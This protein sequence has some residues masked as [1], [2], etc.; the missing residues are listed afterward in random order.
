MPSYDLEQ[1]LHDEGF[2]VVCGVD[3]AGRGPLCGSVVAAA[4]I[5]PDGLEIYYRKF[6]FHIKSS[7]DHSNFKTTSQ[8]S[9]PSCSQIF[10]AAKKRTMHVP[11]S[12]ELINV[13][14][15]CARCPD[16]CTISDYIKND[17]ICLPVVFCFPFTFWAF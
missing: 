5:L 12:K 4:C 15:I 2:A 10:G 6:I 17:R 14:H 16:V 3:E 9:V 1:A 7:N 8:Y 11:A 13:R